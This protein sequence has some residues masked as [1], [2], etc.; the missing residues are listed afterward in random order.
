VPLQQ[1]KRLNLGLVETKS[2]ARLEL[3]LI[4]DAVVVHRST[5]QICHHH[6]PPPFLKRSVHHY[7]IL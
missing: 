5:N 1:L 3:G 7:Y 4:A 2:K 6:L